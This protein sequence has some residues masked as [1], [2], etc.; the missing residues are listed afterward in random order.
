VLIHFRGS[1]A[2][3]SRRRAVRPRR[4]G[5][6][7][8]IVAVV[9]FLAL[10]GCSA[11]APVSARWVVAPTASP[12]P[13]TGL[14]PGATPTPSTSDKALAAVLAALP[15]FPPAPPAS[16]IRLTGGSSA[17]IFYRLP[18]TAPVAFLTMDDGVD[19]LPT[20]LE[21]MQ[22]AG[23]RFTM[24]LIGPVATRNPS[25]FEQLVRDGGVIEDHTMTHPDLK[26][27]SYALQRAEICDARTLLDH[28]FGSPPSLFR[29]PYGDYDATTLR[30]VHDCGLEAAFHWS[31]TVDKGVVHYQSSVHRISPGDIVLMHFRPAFAQDVLAALTAIHAA[32][33][34][35]AL[36][37]DYFPPPL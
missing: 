16:P 6:P 3:A 13:T 30:A 23:I 31:E 28:T 10:S 21:V 18:V 35:P 14:T 11:P 2:A 33:L 17:P 29:P 15:H 20:D 1:R 19:Q 7:V 4:G 12:S 27:K 26:G 37:E 9:G 34:T 22:A 24:F 36:L 8:G 5:W 25:F 32:G